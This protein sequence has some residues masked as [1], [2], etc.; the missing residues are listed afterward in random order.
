LFK[1]PKYAAKAHIFVKFRAKINKIDKAA[2]TG[3]SAFFPP[4]SK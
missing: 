1:N 2:K 3:N 4:G